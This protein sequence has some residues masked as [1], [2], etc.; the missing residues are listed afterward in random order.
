MQF[1]APSLS[2]FDK[3]TKQLQ[4]FDLPFLFDNIEAV[5]RFQQGSDGQR[6][7][8]PP[9]EAE[10]GR[11]SATSSLSFWPISPCGRISRTSMITTHGTMV[12]HWGEM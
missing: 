12:A 9:D 3:F 5:D 6:P 7:R 11:H 1:I 4:L 2:K 8:P 10:R